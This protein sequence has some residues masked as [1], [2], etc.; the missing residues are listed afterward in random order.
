MLGKGLFFIALSFVIS[1]SLGNLLAIYV[2]NGDWLRRI[3]YEVT[4]WVNLFIGYNFIG[5]KS[6]KI[7]YLKLGVLLDSALLTV[8]IIYNLLPEP[9]PVFLSQFQLM[10]RELLLSPLY[11]FFFFVMNRRDQMTSYR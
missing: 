2:E 9:R 10:F 4:I 8:A 6:E 11:F 1:K 3:L 5:N 7:K